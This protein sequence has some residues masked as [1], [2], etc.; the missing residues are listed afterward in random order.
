MGLIQLEDAEYL[1]EPLKGYNI[2]NPTSNAT[3][4]EVGEPQPHL[5]YRRSAVLRQSNAFMHDNFHKE[6]FEGGYR[7]RMSYER[8][9]RR[10]TPPSRSVVQRR[11]KR[12]VSIERNVETLLVADRTMLDYYSNEDIET[13]LLTVLNMEAPL[14]DD[15]GWRR[16]RPD[17][18]KSWIVLS[19]S[20][21]ADFY[22]VLHW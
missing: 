12:S 13:Y 11:K 17:R 18:G 19:L 1:I 2:T 10:E 16:K 3:D 8:R 14:C 9:L 21:F 6:H 5:I 20:L 15:D 4:G 7:E 22:G